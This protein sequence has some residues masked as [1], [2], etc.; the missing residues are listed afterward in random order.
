[1]SGS[2]AAEIARSPAA[3]ERLAKEWLVEVIERT[4]LA[5]VDRLPLGWIAQEAPPLIAEILGQLSD[6]GSARELE[7][8]PAARERAA[9]LAAQHSAGAGAT[10]L[11]RDLAALQSLLIEALG[12]SAPERDRGEFTRAVGRL[13]EVFGAVQSAAIEALVE[14]RTGGARVDESTGMP[15]AA[16]LDEWLRILLGEHRHHDRRFSIAHVKLEGVDRITEAYGGA[17][18]HSM[19]AAVAEVVAR[20][21]GDANQ[22]FRLDHDEIVV[23]APDRA[24]SE[25]ADLGQR[26]AAV[27]ER[28]QSETGPRVA[29]TIGVASCPEHGDGAEELLAA[30]EEAAWGALAEGRAV[31]LAR[32][33]SLQ[34][35]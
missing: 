31:G 18:A 13:A 12:R 14:E 22:A 27:V 8:P 25:V 34:D 21:A 24:T 30:A 1:M 15:G 17:A 10:R 23:L 6:P 32:E 7:L 9:S 28:S 20:E 5:D 16:H 33:G 11:P 26:L 3:W 35:P 4:P 29:I 19:V 2:P